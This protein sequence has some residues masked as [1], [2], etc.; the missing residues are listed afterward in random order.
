VQNDDVTFLDKGLRVHVYEIE[1]SGFK[2]SFVKVCLDEVVE[3]TEQIKVE[4]LNV[5]LGRGFFQKALDSYRIQVGRKNAQEG[6]LI[7][8]H[9]P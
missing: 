7:K 2:F 9:F 1:E 5:F 6:D 3:M 8:R 4:Q